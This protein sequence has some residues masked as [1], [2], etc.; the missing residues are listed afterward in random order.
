MEEVSLLAVIYLHSASNRIGIKL[1]ELGSNIQA[2]SNV[3]SGVLPEN[4]WCMG[5]VQMENWCMGINM[6]QLLPF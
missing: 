3:L 5:L 4:R 1:P 6:V 2:S